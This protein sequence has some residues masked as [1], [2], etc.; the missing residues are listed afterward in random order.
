MQILIILFVPTGI[1]HSSFWLQKFISKTAP[2]KTMYENQSVIRKLWMETNRFTSTYTIAILDLVKILSR[3]Q[4]PKPIELEWCQIIF[5]SGY[6]ARVIG[7]SKFRASLS[8][9]HH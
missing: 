7:L 2:R 5:N 4:G 6:E 1:Q 9:W 8:L 3:I